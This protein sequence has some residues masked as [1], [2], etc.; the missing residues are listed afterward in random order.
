MVFVVGCDRSIGIPGAGLAEPGRRSGF[1]LIDWRG[2]EVC[3]I[4]D[5]AVFE[6][7]AGGGIVPT[8]SLVKTGPD[9]AVV[10]RDEDG[11]L[12]VGELLV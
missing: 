12:V 6:S 11:Y 5:F 1:D 2:W 8:S 7:S 10:G 9:F 4:E 3:P